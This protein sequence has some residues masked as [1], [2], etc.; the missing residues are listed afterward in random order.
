MW[1]KEKLMLTVHYDINYSKRVTTHN[2]HAD[3]SAY[4]FTLFQ[5]VKKVSKLTRPEDGSLRAALFLDKPDRK[6]YPDYYVLVPRPTSLKV[7]HPAFYLHPCLP[8]L[9]LFFFSRSLLASSFSAS[10]SSSYLLV[11]ITSIS[12]SVYLF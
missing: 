6:I 11:L 4:S 7:R 8:F 1:L 12:F 3:S 5:V 10:P 9:H 2:T